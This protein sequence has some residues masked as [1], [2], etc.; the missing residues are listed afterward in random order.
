MTT[1][2]NPTPTSKDETGQQNDDPQDEDDRPELGC[3][4]P[5]GRP[6]ASNGD[7]SADGHQSHAAAHECQLSPREVFQP[8]PEARAM[9]S[10]VHGPVLLRPAGGMGG[11]DEALTPRLVGTLPRPVQ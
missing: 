10:I 8:F 11:R 1:F 2:A 9:A 3:R 6:I 5:I 4:V 7:D